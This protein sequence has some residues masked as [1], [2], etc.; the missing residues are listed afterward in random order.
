MTFKVRP[1]MNL[2]QQGHTSSTSPNS[3]T[4]WRP[5]VPISKGPQCCWPQRMATVP[6]SRTLGPAAFTPESMS[7]RSSKQEFTKPQ[8]LGQQVCCS[9]SGEGTGPVS[10]GWF[11][12]N[13]VLSLR[14]V[15]E[16]LLSWCAWGPGFSPGNCQETRCSPSVARLWG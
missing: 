11:I 9:P 14:A 15:V 10:L 8:E 5:S 6:G 7:Y 1:E 16:H 4:S 2:L 12:E 3:P 13:T